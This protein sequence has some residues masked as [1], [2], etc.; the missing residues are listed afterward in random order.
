M[1]DDKDIEEVTSLVD[2]TVRGCERGCVR[3]WPLLCILAAL[4]TGG[5]TV[6]DTK[7]DKTEFMQFQL[8]DKVNRQ[9]EASDICELKVMVTRLYNE[10]LPK[11][12]RWPEPICKNVGGIER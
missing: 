10:G 12:K 9:N 11:D 7:V 6:S 8:A 3:W 1:L 5:W 4:F 2:R